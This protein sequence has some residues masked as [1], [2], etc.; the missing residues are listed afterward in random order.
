M[1]RTRINSM[2]TEIIDGMKKLYTAVILL[3][4]GLV[5]TALWFSPLSQLGTPTAYCDNIPV[6][7]LD[8]LCYPS[9]SPIRVDFSGSEAELYR[10]LDIMLADTVKTTE[11]DGMLLV[12]AHSPR[13]C[14]PVMYTSEG[15]VYNVMAAY[16]DGRICIGTPALAGCY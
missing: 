2:E 7:A 15:E 3:S 14:A 8:G 16:S 4:A 9:D 11:I 5:F 12:Y 1:R 13:V 10:S 6:T